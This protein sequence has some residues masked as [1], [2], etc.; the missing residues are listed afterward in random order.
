[1]NDTALAA[2]LAAWRQQQS[3]A[4]KERPE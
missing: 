1:L 3:D 2:R 4:V